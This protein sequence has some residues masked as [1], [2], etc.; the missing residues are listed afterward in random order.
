[1][2]ESTFFDGEDGFDAVQAVGGESF[3]AFVAVAFDDAV[4]LLDVDKRFA[5]DFMGVLVPVE[6]V[7]QDDVAIGVGDADVAVQVPDVGSFVI[8][9]A[10]AFQRGGGFVVVVEFFGSDAVGEGPV[11]QFRFFEQ[12]PQRRDDAVTR[13]S[14]LR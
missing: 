4:F 1:M 6:P 9:G 2:R 3:V 11:R 7:G 8:V 10:V 5:V 12:V 14:L 13:V